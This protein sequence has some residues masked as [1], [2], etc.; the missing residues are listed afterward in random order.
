MASGSSLT[1]SLGKNLYVPLTSRC[2][3]NPLP[4][5]RG[6]NFL[7]HPDVVASLCRVRDCE[8]DT[9]QWK[10]WCIWLDMQ[11]SSQKL[12]VSFETVAEIPKDV[13]A[14]RRP[15]VTE[16]LEE[17]QLI[18]E[19]SSFDAI[20][21]SGEGEPTLRMK[22]LLQ[23]VEQ[24][25]DEKPDRNVR[26]TTNGLAAADDVAEQLQAA[27]VDSIS[28]ALMTHDPALYDELMRPVL[29]THEYQAHETVCNFLKQAVQVG[30]KVEVTG[31][32]REEVN[33]AE[34]EKLALSLGVDEP[35]RWRT[36]HP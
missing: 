10:H 33:K 2:N 29:S 23:L 3:A 6:S 21:I 35:F 25:K 11:E 34:T 19:K 24:L 36:Y 4:A 27:G 7:L 20:V 14:T 26:V 12:P 22:A 1:Y 13:D 15:T 32:D 28:V 9:V 8:H 30:L 18:S 31:V 17:I 16:L 5:T